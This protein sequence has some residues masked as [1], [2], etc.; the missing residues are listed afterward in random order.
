MEFRS[1]MTF[2]KNT[3]DLTEILRLQ[4][5]ELILFMDNFANIYYQVNGKELMPLAKMPWKLQLPFFLTFLH[6]DVLADR[7]KDLEVIG[8]IDLYLKW[9]ICNGE[10][11]SITGA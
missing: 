10:T 5:N 2:E 4:K 6:D 8:A 11:I 7:F 1:T 9:K 3:Y